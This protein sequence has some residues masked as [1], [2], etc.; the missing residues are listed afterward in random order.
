M[1]FLPDFISSLLYEK[2]N[3]QIVGR[4]PYALMVALF[5]HLFADIYVEEYYGWF[6]G[7]TIASPIIF[8][9]GNTYFNRKINTLVETGLFSIR[10]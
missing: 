5:A 10:D 2:L 8:L 9:V 3:K 4:V 6:L 1:A 7:G